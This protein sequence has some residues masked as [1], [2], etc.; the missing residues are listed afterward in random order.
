MTTCS[1]AGYHKFGYAKD[2]VNSFLMHNPTSYLTYYYDKRPPHEHPRLTAKKLVHPGIT[3]LKRAA[4][5]LPVLAGRLSYGQY[6]YKLDAFSFCHKV[7]A[8]L[9][10]ARYNYLLEEPCQ[11]IWLDSDVEVINPFPKDLFDQFKGHD[12]G[13]LY[14]KGNHSCT[15]FLS[16]MVNTNTLSFLHSMASIFESGLILMLQE[17]NDAYLLDVLL[18]SIHDPCK[19]AIFADVSLSAK[20][21]SAP[22]GMNIES[23]VFNLVFM[24]YM[25]HRKGTRK[26]QRR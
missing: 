13:Y 6:A 11:L 21:L 1:D 5:Q 12:L 22:E 7:F 20:R 19:V 9:L 16:W 24:P 15:S 23:E 26:Y 18:G 25:I 4:A 17:W 2:F 14:R 8:M 10:E 3:K